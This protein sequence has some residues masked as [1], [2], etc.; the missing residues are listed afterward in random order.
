MIAKL[1]KRLFLKSQKAGHLVVFSSML[2]GSLYSCANG[3]LKRPS[4]QQAQQ[5]SLLKMEMMRLWA[6]A[7]YRRILGDEL[8][9]QALERDLEV[10]EQELHDS[11]ANPQEALSSR[12]L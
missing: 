10:L 11:E 3:P 2:G 7:E 4:L 8:G 6:K 9:A 1:T 5:K 12:N